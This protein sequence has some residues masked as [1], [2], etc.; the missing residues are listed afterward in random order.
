MRTRPSKQRT[1]TAVEYAAPDTNWVSDNFLKSV[2]ICKSQG[3]F[4]LKCQLGFK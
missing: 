4:D 3:L 2:K 1:S